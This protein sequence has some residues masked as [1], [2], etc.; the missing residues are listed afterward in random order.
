M[1][2]I[3]YVVGPPKCMLVRL[4]ADFCKLQLNC[5]HVSVQ[6]LIEYDHLSCV[7]KVGALPQVGRWGD[8]CSTRCLRIV[9]THT[10]GLWGLHG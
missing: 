2:H 3:A 8:P 6:Y 4:G 7:V 10:T 1:L 5:M 9:P